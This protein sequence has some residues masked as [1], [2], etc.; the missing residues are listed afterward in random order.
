MSAW[1]K[2]TSKV[3]VATI[4]ATAEKKMELERLI[5]R[6]SDNGVDY[7]EAAEEEEDAA[8]DTESDD[9]GSDATPWPSAR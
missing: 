6:L 1:L 3:L 8:E 7:G 2:Y 4:G 5:K 9:D